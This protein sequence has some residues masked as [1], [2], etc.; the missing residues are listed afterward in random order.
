[1][2]LWISLG[3]L[4]ADV[5]HVVFHFQFPTSSASETEMPVWCLC[6]MS[7][8]YRS[9]SVHSVIFFLKKWQAV[10][11]TTESC[12]WPLVHRSNRSTS[13]FMLYTVRY[14]DIAPFRP[15]IGPDSLPSSAVWLSQRPHSVLGP[16]ARR[17]IESGDRG[18]RG[19]GWLGHSQSKFY[20]YDY[21]E[22]HI[23]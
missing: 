17:A 6:T 5:F 10:I 4:N 15:R 9:P 16:S 23:I 22:W 3:S 19:S 13:P 11:F 20:G 14:C 1:M 8:C 18:A 21:L 2:K 7:N 12:A